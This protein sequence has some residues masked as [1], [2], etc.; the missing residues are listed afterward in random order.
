[1]KNEDKILNL[2]SLRFPNHK[3]LITELFNESESFRSLCEDYYDCRKLLD[4]SIKI[5][6]KSGDVRKE[7]QILLKEIEDEL[8]EKILS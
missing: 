3:E 2:T 1:M 6:N 5:S 4:D 8:L 7:Y